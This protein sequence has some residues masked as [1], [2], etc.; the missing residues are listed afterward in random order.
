M[1]LSSCF[2]IYSPR[3]GI[4]PSLLLKRVLMYLKALYQPEVNPVCTHSPPWQVAVLS[5]SM[6][7]PFKSA[8]IVGDTFSTH[9]VRSR[10]EFVIVWIFLAAE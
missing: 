5:G 4:M 8:L 6:G 7:L 10:H 3:F 2:L 1:R 9:F